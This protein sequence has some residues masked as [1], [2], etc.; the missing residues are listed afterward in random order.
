M[1]ASWRSAGLAATAV[2]VLGT[3]ACTSTASGPAADSSPSTSATSGPTGVYGAT[4]NPTRLEPTEVATD[5]P[6]TVQP[7]PDI[8][9]FVTYSGWNSL[10]GSV[11]VGGYVAGVVESDGT[12]TLTL[13]RGSTEVTGS[14]PATPDVGT[15]SCGGLTVPGSAV[16]AGT[17][18]AVVGYD[19]DSSSGSSDPVE[20]TVP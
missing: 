8:S 2:A 13:T 6:V 20:V 19:S 1:Q 16:S 4:D 17:W 10:S 12:C 18:T 14:T 5:Q 11:D 7:G 9:V 3:A 15:T